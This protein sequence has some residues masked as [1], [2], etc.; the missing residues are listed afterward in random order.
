MNNDIEELKQMIEPLKDWKFWE[1]NCT[2]EDVKKAMETKSY[3]EVVMEE[4]DKTIKNLQQEL[5]RKDNIIKE[6]KKY[7]K[8]KTQHYFDEIYF[9]ETYELLLNEEELDELNDILDNIKELEN[10]KK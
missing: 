8:N 4:Q 2:D 1:Y 10:E 6:A 3:V 9:K 7:I 5:Q